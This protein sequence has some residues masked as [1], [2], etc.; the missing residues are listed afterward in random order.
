MPELISMSDRIYVMCEGSVAGVLRKN[1][2]TQEAIL[3]L[4]SG[5][6]L[7]DEK[8]NFLEKTR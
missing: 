1:E 3:S 6:A 5:Q 8:I 7:S 4:A 2:V